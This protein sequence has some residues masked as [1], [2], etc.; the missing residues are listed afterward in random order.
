MTA[1]F[2][3]KKT[4]GHRPEL[5]KLVEKR[6]RRV[7]LPTG[8]GG[9]TRRIRAGR[10]KRFGVSAL[11]RHSATLSRWERALPETGF[12]SAIRLKASCSLSLTEQKSA[13]WTRVVTARRYRRLGDQCLAQRLE[14]GPGLRDYFQQRRAI[15]I[16][17]MR[18]VL[19]AILADENFP[20]TAVDI[21]AGGF[22]HPVE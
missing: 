11:T 10:P 21:A 18:E 15:R 20:Q 2:I 4:G 3:V 14:F 7:L 9:A 8:E 13:I 6:L 19:R 17:E 1:G 16:R 5:S 12:H 22:R